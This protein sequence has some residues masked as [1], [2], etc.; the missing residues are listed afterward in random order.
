MAGED[1]AAAPD[2]NG[3]V[4]ANASEEG[5]VLKCCHVMDK[6]LFL[7]FF[8]DIDFEIAY[9][10]RLEKIANFGLSPHQNRK[11]WTFLKTP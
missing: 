1:T 2:G 5:W 7:F 6:D 10:V 3:K 9:P 4:D 8:F 11:F